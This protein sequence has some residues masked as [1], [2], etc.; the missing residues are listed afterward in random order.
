MLKL[1]FFK[2]LVK[3]KF[4][5]ISLERKIFLPLARP[6]KEKEELNNQGRNHM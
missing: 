4:Q 6:A 2:D 3:P 5:P 1:K